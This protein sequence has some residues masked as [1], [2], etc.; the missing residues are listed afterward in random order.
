MSKR[1]M[2]P[3]VILALTA[4]VAA[5]PAE[6]QRG[7]GVRGGA[8]PRGPGGPNLGRS[9]DVALENQEEL[10]LTGEQVAQLTEMKS[11]MDQELNPLAEEIKTLRAGIQSGEIDRAQGVRDLQALQGQFIASS[12]PLRGRV[13]EILT[14]EQHNRLQPM[15]WQGRPGLG[16]GAAF[17][18]R[19]ARGAGM[20]TPM[21]G[22]RGGPGFRSGF[23]GQGR[24]PAFGFRARPR[25]MLPRRSGRIGRTGW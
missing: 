10:G 8:G 23:Q 17:G 9:V 20:R 19:G 21:R 16:R 14:V 12:A 24:V 11:L 18:G 7:M 15:V 2:G 4:L 3:M 25:R 1:K 5:V 6:A 22:G 13:Q